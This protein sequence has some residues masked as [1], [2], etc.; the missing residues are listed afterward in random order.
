MNPSFVSPVLLSRPLRLHVVRPPRPS[1]EEDADLVQ[2]LRD[3]KRS[4]EE[5]LYRRHAPAVLGLATR[6]LGRR[7]DAED[8][9]QDTFLVAFDT[10]RQLRDPKALQAWIL[11]IAVSQVQRRFRKRRLLRRLGLDVGADDATLESLLAAGAGPEVKADLG[12]VD[13]VLA[14]L[15]PRNRVAWMLRH[16]EGHRL[17]EVARLCGCSLATAKRRIAAADAQVHAEVQL[18]PGDLW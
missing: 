1:G 16:V 8:A 9:V 13:R 14:K 6:L 5:T 12:A 18:S 4:A 11:R 3:G 7:S 17:D 15:A 2:G 10:I